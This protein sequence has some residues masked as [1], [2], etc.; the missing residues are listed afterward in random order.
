MK[1]NRIFG[2]V[3]AAA[4]M[5]AAACSNDVIDPNKNQGH[6]NTDSSG[7]VY[8]SVDFTMPSANYETTRSV[9]ID[10]GGSDSGTEIGKDYEN[11][12][13]NA[14]IVIAATEAKA[15]ARINQY[16]FIVAGEVPGNRIGTATPN[17]NTGAKRYKATARLQKENL[18]RLYQT[19]GDNNV[20]DV[21]V[22]VFCNP[23]QELLSLFDDTNTA[24]GSSA[25]ID[26]TC[27]V[28]QSTDATLDYNVGVW[29]ANSFLMNNVNLATREL[30]KKLLDWENY[31]TIENPFHLS[32]KN[33]R[34]E[35]NVD[36][37]PDNN[38][39]DVL[40]ERSVARFDFKD[41][42]E[43]GNNTYEVLMNMNKEGDMDTTQPV[44][45]I[46]IQKMCLVNMSKSFY[47]LPRVSENGQALNST[48]CG[49]EKPW[50]RNN[51]DGTYTGGNYIVGPNA[52]EFAKGVNTDFSKYFNFPFFED[53]GSFN[54]EAMSSTRWDVAKVE[55][56]LKGEGDEYNK[57]DGAK[58]G[59]YHIWRYVTENLIPDNEDNQMNG[60]S[61]GVV[62]KGKLLGN[63]KIG[64]AEATY[65][66]EYWNEGNLVNL[67]NCLNGKPFTYNSETITLTGKSDHD[68]ILYYFS[69]QLYLGWRHIR[70]A[71]IQ[72]SV[73]VNS[74]NV[75]E[76]N[77]S[78]SLYKAVFGDGPIPT[79]TVDGVEHKM[80][81]VTDDNRKVEIS[82]PMWDVVKANPNGEEAEWYKSSANYAWSQW[83]LN[84]KEVGDDTTGAHS[85]ALLQAMRAAV[86]NAGITIYQSSIDS[87]YGAG[88]YCYY[89][90]WNR[91]NDNGLNGS[92]G[93]ME[94]DVVRNNVYKLSVDKIARLGHPRIPEN[95]PNNPTPDTPDEI[96]EIY[97]DVKMEIVPWV[98][99]VNSIVF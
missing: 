78:N 33:D 39:G 38:R 15:D 59:E 37:S 85:P 95:D 21:Y 81:Y 23:T 2:M 28:L 20:P 12:V 8:L 87:D 55:D 10:G 75:M 9:T 89:Y 19:Y 82:D 74:Q 18:N 46:Q 71:A 48:L 11:Y 98:V 43:V 3:S 16:G 67:A 54:N 36:N 53:N 79:Y 26:A 50:F 22:F 64:S 4:L 40:V 88:Y 94:F 30:P 32:D 29:G 6:L 65:D 84:G 69:G 92:M 24:F 57:K 51:V 52:L 31:S 56:V 97:L 13:S 1:T 83:A 44:V 60:I 5:M 99:R 47:Y 27:E 66:E 17:P 58:Y 93:P 76:I 14:L 45:D 70:Q 80:V 86:I 73:T 42:S 62:F 41:G 90:Y 63:P 25:W 72:A 68:P 49:R 61:T 96:D 7:G 77:R 34:S 91:H 35:V